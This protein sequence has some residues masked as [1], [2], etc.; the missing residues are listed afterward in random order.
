[1][2]CAPVLRHE[3]EEL[4]VAVEA[5]CAHLVVHGAL[6]ASGFDH[7]TDTDAAV[8]EARETQ[9]MQALGFAD[10]YAAT[11]DTAGSVITQA[12]PGPAT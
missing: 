9:V 11:P 3:A 12:E 5:H 4:G 7:E 6:H 8:M 2:L 1:V 10:P